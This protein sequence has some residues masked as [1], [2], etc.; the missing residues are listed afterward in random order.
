MFRKHIATWQTVSDKE[1]LLCKFNCCLRVITS[2]RPVW[3]KSNWSF[4]VCV[5]PWEL[6]QP[7]N[8]V[9][10]AH[11]T[12][13]NWQSMFDAS[14]DKCS[15][16]YMACVWWYIHTGVHDY[17]PLPGT[18]TFHLDVDRCRSRCLPTSSH[19]LN[20]DPTHQPTPSLTSIVKPT[21]QR[22]FL[23][24]MSIT[25]FPVS[26]NKCTRIKGRR[27]WSWRKCGMNTYIFTDH[28][29]KTIPFLIN[30]RLW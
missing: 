4:V 18:R 27:K 10:S 3:S 13:Y 16:W 9:F 23:I 6:L 26:V 29:K 7:W 22:T 5:L 15:P 17:I 28:L 30:G 21:H 1:S 24:M 20:R 25:L 12:E 8:I 2:V 11:H 19:A 14:I